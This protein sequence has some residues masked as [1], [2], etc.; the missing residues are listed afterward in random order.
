MNKLHTKNLML[1][2]LIALP[3]IAQNVLAHGYISSPASRS[4]QC[5]LGD[6]VNCGA[7][8]WEPQSVE[9]PDRYPET[10]PAD[11]KIAS[12]GV[13]HFSELDEQSVNRWNKLPMQAGRNTFSWH[14][15]ANHATRDWRYFITKENW[16]PNAPLKRSSFEAQ[17]FCTHQGNN[18]RPPTDLSHDCDVP[19]RSG[20]HVILGVWDVGDTVNS[21]YQVIDVNFDGDNPT[22]PTTW[23]DIGDINPSIDLMPGDQVKTRV[24]DGTGENPG[25]QTVLRID[26]EDA[27]RKNQWPFQLAT[28]INNESD[29][30]RAGKQ[31]HDGDIVPAYGQN[32]IF[33]TID[34]GIERVEVEIVKG[35]S[36][37]PQLDLSGLKSEYAI[38]SGMASIDFTVST[39]ANMKVSAFAYAPDG[40]AAGFVEASVNNTSYNFL[41]DIKEAKAGAY[42]L[43]IKGESKD[44]KVVQKT[45]G[46]LLK[47]DGDTNPP[48]GN[49]DHVYPDN[50]QSYKDGTRVLARDGKIYRCKPFPYSGW[51]TIYSENANHYEP[52]VGAYWQD[53]WVLAD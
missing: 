30:L 34:S 49:Y 16:N 31:N 6:N 47:D 29:Y 52:G 27:G 36:T 53:A 40:S 39:N 51:C 8:Q 2:C 17:P 19:S 22:D 7:I 20:Y 46:F 3:F 37:E 45:Q 11:G 13:S 1:G 9:G 48:D 12:A 24:F 41:L 50:L 42:S 18:Q 35:D 32:D 5:K 15:T 14:F 26:S 38:E 28:A 43:V 25:L 44:G 10:G 23:Q 33:T 21:F 4:Y